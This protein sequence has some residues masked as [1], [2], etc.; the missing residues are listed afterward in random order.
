MGKIK[1][2]KEPTPTISVSNKVRQDWNAFIDF[3]ESKGIKGNPQLD[4]N[5]LGN[6]YLNE[7]I[8]ENPKTSLSESLIVPIQND[9]QNYR[10]F[11]L[12]RIKKGEAKFGIGVNEDNFMKNLSNVDGIVGQYTSQVKF[13][14]E[15]LQTLD[16]E[17]NTIIDKSKVGFSNF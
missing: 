14:P 11:A 7:F 5:K 12:E 9:F 15:Y 4:S 16:R 13:P 1:V 10:K 2:K 6:Q 17:T 8:K 3:L